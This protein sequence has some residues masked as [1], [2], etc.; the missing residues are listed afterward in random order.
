LYHPI[1]ELEERSGEGQMTIDVTGGA[2]INLMGET[3]CTFLVMKQEEKKSIELSRHTR[4]DNSTS[5]CAYPSHGEKFVLSILH[6]PTK[7]D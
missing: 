2:C 6:F 5:V 1:L 3:V 4:A 7:L